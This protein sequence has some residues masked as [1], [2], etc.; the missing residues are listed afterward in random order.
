[1]R[2]LYVTLIAVGAAIATSIAIHTPAIASSTVGVGYDTNTEIANASGAYTRTGS[3]GALTN[4]AGTAT[5]IS[6]A[7]TLA[8]KVQ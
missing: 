2:S 8:L 3:T 4:W 1:M 6:V 5:K 7:V